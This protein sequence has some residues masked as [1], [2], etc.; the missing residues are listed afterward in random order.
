VKF[1]VTL[2]LLC[3]SFPAF[4][5]MNIEQIRQSK[6]EGTAGAVGLKV[7]GQT[8]NSKKLLSEATTL[9]VQRNGKSEYLLAG[10]YRYGSS[11]NVKD[12]HQGNAHF[13]FTQD[14]G[15]SPSAEAFLQTEFDQ[16]K[17]LA[18]RDL[19]GVG[20]RQLVE[21]A[22]GNSLFVGGGIFHENER[23]SGG[24][25]PNQNAFRINMYIAFVRA[26]SKTVSGSATIYYQ[27]K[28]SVP[29]DMRAQIDS[30]L[31]VKLA[32]YLALSLEWDLQADT[33]PP[34]GVQTVDT[35]YLVGLNFTY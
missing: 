25:V 30:A 27:P 7:N 3:A 20:A 16:F 12:T 33:R 5:F 35:T 31:Q 22:E 29:S 17:R 21:R 13:R 18:R 34:P 19:I 1:L 24:G 23:F 15:N 28:L 6:K 14:F 26:F 9:T 10:L 8:G 2:I 32:E 4:A 11:R